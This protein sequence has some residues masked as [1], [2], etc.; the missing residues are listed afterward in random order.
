MLTNVM[1]PDF[2]LLDHLFAEKVFTARQISV[3]KAKETLFQRNE[4][5]LQYLL[6]LGTSINKIDLFVK[7]LK[8]TGQTHIINYIYNYEAAKGEP[9]SRYCNFY[10]ID[11]FMNKSVYCYGWLCVC[12]RVRVR[13]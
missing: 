3:I 5:I 9:Q 11:S 1:D 4:Q 8:K 13:V 6:Q 7:S 2:G 12:V 10:Y